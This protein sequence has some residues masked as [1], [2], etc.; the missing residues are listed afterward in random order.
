MITELVARLCCIKR[1][2]ERDRRKY[3]TANEGLDASPAQSLEKSAI[4]PVPRIIHRGKL[5]AST[6]M[7]CVSSSLVI[8]ADG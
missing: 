2:L 7:P 1:Y 3:L 6:T 5:F 8:K 4:V